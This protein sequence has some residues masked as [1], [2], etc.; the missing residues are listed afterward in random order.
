MQEALIRKQNPEYSVNTLYRKP[1]K[2]AIQ[3]AM[4][5]IDGLSEEEAK[6]VIVRLLAGEL[7]DKTDKR[8]KRCVFCGYYWRDDSL[9]NT[10]KTC[11]DE[12]HTGKKTLQKRKQRE[13]KALLDQN[14]EYKHKLED[15]Y[16]FWLEYPYWLSESSMIK[17]NWKHEVPYEVETV[18][19]I[20]TNSRIYGKGNRKI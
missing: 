14:K 9:R 6:S 10:K 1:G 4:Q 5:F 17:L 19:F 2:G 8:I 3:F 13:R 18:D 15:D 12:C 16:I 11:S 7:H 20:Q